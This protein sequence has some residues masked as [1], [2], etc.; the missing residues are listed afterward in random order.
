MGRSKNTLLSS[1]RRRSPKFT[2][3]REQPKAAED[4]LAVLRMRPVKGEITR[5]EFD[6]LKKA[7]KGWGTR[8]ACG[9]AF[10]PV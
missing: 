6:G 7:I 5:G 8:R 4:P 10:A 9:A 1:E 2:R 3:A